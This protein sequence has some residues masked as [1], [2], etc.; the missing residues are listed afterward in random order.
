MDMMRRGRQPQVKFTDDD[1]L[2]IRYSGLGTKFLAEM[3]KTSVTHMSGI[4]RGRTHKHVPINPDLGTS[5]PAQEPKEIQQI[6][7]DLRT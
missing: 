3:F 1:V 4:K 5:D 6:E 2:F 7:L